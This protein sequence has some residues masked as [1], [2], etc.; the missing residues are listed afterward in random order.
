MSETTKKYE[1]AV[2]VIAAKNQRI[3]DLELH[4]RLLKDEL[5]EQQAGWTEAEA[6]ILAMAEEVK[7]LQKQYLELK[8]AVWACQVEE[9]T[10]L[11]ESE[12]PTHADTL[13]EINRIDRA[14]EAAGGNDADTN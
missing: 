3:K 14:A 10:G 8:A 12:D 7:R 11:A 6:V 13:V 2:E 1:V 4:N 9:V 5:A